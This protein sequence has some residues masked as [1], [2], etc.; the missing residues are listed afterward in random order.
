MAH[1]FRGG[2]RLREDRALFSAPIQ[3]YQAGEFVRLP[4]LFDGARY[5]A[6][7]TAGDRV[8]KGQSLLRTHA[9]EQPF[10][11]HAPVSGKVVKIESSAE[12]E[13]NAV[14]LL[15]NDFKEELC[16]DIAPFSESIASSTPEALEEV[17]RRRGL[18]DPQGDGTPLFVRVQKA[19]GKAK[20][21]IIACG[22][23]DAD[24]AVHHRLILD[25]T[26]E[27]VGGAK[28]LL[29]ALGAQRAVFAVSLAREEEVEVLL[30][31]TKDSDAFD[32]LSIRAMYPAMEDAL[33]HF[34]V[35]GKK[36]PPRQ[37]SKAIEVPV[38]SAVLCFHVYRAF[39]TGLPQ[40]TSLISAGGGAVAEP[41]NLM[42]PI[43]TSV[44]EAIDRCGGLAGHGG[45]I[46]S[47]GVMRGVPAQGLR[48]IITK[49]TLAITCIE[50]TTQ[51]MPSVCLSCGRC[52]SACPVQ[53]NPKAL[54]TALG[55][56]KKKEEKAIQ[57]IASFCLQC[58]SCSFVCPAHLPLTETFSRAQRKGEEKQ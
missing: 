50:E 27:V 45:I 9:F 26:Q 13:K 33:L 6:L 58:G 42:I 24:I 57:R 5:E 8:K 19:R 12:D 34:A 32:V 49:K 40:I 39:T 48:E 37:N 28:I 3:A 36:D 2:I 22:G 4:L 10:D 38:F 16:E 25:H 29:R 52:L 47:G 44:R 51:A 23:K 11:V 55:N 53:L 31:K 43:G 56:K 41:A 17:L 54:Y 21:V 46:L 18:L 35:T 30:E 7:V 20:T 14:L 1:S 15:E